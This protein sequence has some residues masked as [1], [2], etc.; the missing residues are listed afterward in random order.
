MRFSA[1]G[2]Y[3]VRAMIDLALH[4]SG[5]PISARAVAERQEIS[6]DF[7][8]Q[9]FRQLRRKKLVHSTRGPRGGFVLA[10][11]AGEI[12]VLDILS[13]L[14]ESFIV[15]PCLE[16]HGRREG[17]SCAREQT[18]SARLLWES[19]EAGIQDVLARTTLADIVSRSSDGNEAPSEL[20]A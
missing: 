7:L 1:K 4:Q 5:R 20:P 10:R 17:Q 3:G 15:A 19:V 2:R 9:I 14:D 13:A 16:Q 6:A 11:P 12:N 8:E 18:C